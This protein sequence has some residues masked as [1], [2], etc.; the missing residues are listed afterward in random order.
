MTTG[1][2][3]EKEYV[4]AEYTMGTRPESTEAEV[5]ERGEQ[6]GYRAREQGEDVKQNVASGMHRAAQ[7]LRGQG[8]KRGQGSMAAQVAEP[9]ERSAEYLSSH[10]LPEIRNDAMRTAEQHPL[11]AAA[12]V[13]ATAFLV[14]RLLRRR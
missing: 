10:S 3:G 2:R 5:R 9:L 1:G 7:T 4:R 11:W 6:M 14:G 13:F 8:M 12:G